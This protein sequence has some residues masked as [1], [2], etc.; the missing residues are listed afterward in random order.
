L[1]ARSRLLQDLLLSLVPELARCLDEL[2]DYRG[3]ADF[4]RRL[5]ALELLAILR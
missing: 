3:Q 1:L 5:P 2:P 4:R